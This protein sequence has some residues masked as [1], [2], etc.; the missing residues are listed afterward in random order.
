MRFAVPLTILIF[1]AGF[2]GLLVA[3]VLESGR[4][5]PLEVI[6]VLIL[7]MLVFG[8]VGALRHPDDD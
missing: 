5:G 7:A 1:T 3:S 8:A 2:G 4:F 6:T